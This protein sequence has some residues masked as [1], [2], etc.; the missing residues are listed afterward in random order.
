MPV[1]GKTIFA[2]DDS[3]FILKHLEMMLSG[4]P[5]IG[6]LVSAGSYEDAIPVLESEKPY[7]V[8]LDINLPD[9]S[10]IELLRYI[11]VRYP[12]MIV[13]ML[14]N[15]S[16]EIYR[17]RCKALGAS[18]FIDKSTEFELVPQIISSFL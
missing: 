15:Q 16:D 11:K 7:L 6:R 2:V 3:L 8:L 18:H 10:G 17:Q 12:E 13:I 9:R 5:G 4:M 1:K 14:S